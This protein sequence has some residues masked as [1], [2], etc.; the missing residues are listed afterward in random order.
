MCA[1]PQLL[2]NHKICSRSSQLIIYAIC[3]KKKLTYLPVFVIIISVPNSWN[4]SHNSL[5]S[6][7]HWTGFNSSQLHE[8]CRPGLC[9]KHFFLVEFIDMI[10]EMALFIITWTGSGDNRSS[11]DGLGGE[12][13]DVSDVVRATL[14]WASES[15]H[16]ST[17]TSPSSSASVNL[18]T[19]MG[20]EKKKRNKWFFCGLA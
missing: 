4:L 10:F 6:K 20:P 13:I 19:D 18:S 3:N 11:S 15:L 14:E 2:R 7:W 1:A 12:F 8:P 16:C 17:S 9:C 5:V